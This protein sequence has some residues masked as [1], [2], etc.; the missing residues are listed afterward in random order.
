MEVALETHL[1]NVQQGQRSR[2][3][4]YSLTLEHKM[5]LQNHALRIH[6]TVS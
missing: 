5:H 4:L 6:G 2:C 3:S 1:E